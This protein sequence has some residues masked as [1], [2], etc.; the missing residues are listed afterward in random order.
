MKLSELRKKKGISQ[1][2]LARELFFPVATIRNWEHG[3]SI[4][5]V[6]AIR[7]MAEIFEVN[8][9]DIFEMFMPQSMTANKME[10]LEQEG[11]DILQ[12]L[13]KSSRNGTQ[14]IFFASAVGVFPESSGIILFEDEAFRFEKINAV[15]YGTAVILSD[16]FDN[17]IVLTERNILSVIPVSSVH[18]VYI[19][20]LEIACP[21]FQTST[22][23]I[24]HKFKQRIRV[25][26]F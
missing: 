13:F 15:I 4:P 7:K 11:F 22:K 9:E 19:F 2:K 18:G 20:E 10:E 23:F 5:S 1:E 6:N 8:V 14:F 24:S 26:F 17:K 12:D 21:F 3:K 25:L 16:R